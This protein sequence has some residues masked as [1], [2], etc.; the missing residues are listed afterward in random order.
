M[1]LV[2]AVLLG[3]LQ[4]LTEFL[5]V[6]SSGHLVLAQHFLGVEEPQLFFDVVLHLGTLGAVF[7]VYRRSLAR[8]LVAL[9]RGLSGGALLRSP[10]RALAAAPDLRLLAWVA[11]GSVPAAF[12]GLLLEDQVE[13]AFGSP[14]LTAVFLI[15]TGLILQAPRLR[16]REW[17][18]D[19]PVGFRQAC[20]VGLAQALAILP[21]ISRSGSTISA[22]LLG[23]VAPGAAAE[24]SF[25]LSI[26]AILGAAVLELARVETV[27]LSPVALVAGTATSFL[28]GWG[29]L[30]LLLATLN[31]GRFSTFSYYCFALAAAALPALSLGY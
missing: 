19:R 12:V 15:G 7:L 24:F 26:P 23:G 9:V 2:A 13:A 22:A 3:V 30:R 1:S 25:L 11:V 8:L 31:R 16:P 20:G 27:G 4:G 6:S 5:P 18:R 21:G 17:P 14:A 29:A 28:V 10:A